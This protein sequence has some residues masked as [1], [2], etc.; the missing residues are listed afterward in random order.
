MS[1]FMTFLAAP[2]LAAV[3]AAFMVWTGDRSRTTRVW[4]APT[5]AAVMFGTF[6]TLAYASPIPAPRA[7]FVPRPHYVCHLEVRP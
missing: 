3:A 4:L 6:F 1:V 5:C 7:H 2:L